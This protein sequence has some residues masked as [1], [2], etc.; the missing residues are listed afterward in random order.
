M[1]LLRL[2]ELI[3]H[4]GKSNRHDNAHDIDAQLVR[5]TSDFFQCFFHFRIDARHSFVDLVHFV[6]DIFEHDGLPLDFFALER[7]DLGQILNAL[8]N[9]VQLSIEIGVAL[10]QLQNL[11]P[12][13]VG[14]SRAA[15]SGASP[16]G[17]FVVA[18]RFA[19]RNSYK[20]NKIFSV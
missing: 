3:N 10:F 6:V 1:Q 2:N 17:S 9:L 15:P 13:I 11:L 7:G 20:K 12:L 5:R 4:R 16:R 18:A 19:Y 14:N 8:A